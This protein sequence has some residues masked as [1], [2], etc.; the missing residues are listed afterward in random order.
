MPIFNGTSGPDNIGG[1]ET[2]DTINGLGG[3]DLLG[4]FGGNDTIRGGDGDDTVIGGDGNDSIFGE[5]H[6]DLLLG[7]TGAD[8]VDGGAG[9]DILADN[10]IFVSGG[11]AT[12][13]PDG[14]RDDL[15]GGAGDDM[16]TGGLFDVFDGGTGS[17]LALINLSSTSGV[18]VDFRPMNTGGAGALPSGGSIRNV[19]A[20]INVTFGSG[21]NTAWGS[22]FFEEFFGGSGADTFDG[23]GG[24]DD[25]RGFGGN[26][27]IQGGDGV[28]AI[29]GGDG[30]D[31]MRGGAGADSLNGGAGVDTADYS[32]SAAGVTVDLA[33]GAA[34]GG[35]AAG[36]ILTQIENVTGS[37]LADILAG[38]TAA[39]AFNGGGGDD[40]INGGGGVDTA[41]FASIA[42][43]AAVWHRNVDGSWTITGT[44][45]ADTLANVEFLDFSDRGVFL[46][47]ASRTFSGNG[48]SDVLFRRTDGIIASWEVS[49]T[50]IG[51][52]HFL[53]TAGAEWSILATGD[54]SG[55]GR[56]DVIWRRDNGLVY[57]GP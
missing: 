47:R 18:T 23:G 5:N 30:D 27:A 12:A 38:T 35:D 48:T 10:D 33:T 29:Q 44:D 2:A 39:N 16:L 53:P 31:V 46:D 26:D 40:A 4:G 56:D 54:I 14:S 11:V 22:N 25:L 3:D 1:S 51:S 8:L 37:A 45:G 7:E 13:V 28:D 17:D 52:A 43:D 57:P 9:A 24:G 42:S 41:V 50:T 55:D 20:G 19:E 49:G 34:A 32:A 21:A 15:R 36:D 6:D